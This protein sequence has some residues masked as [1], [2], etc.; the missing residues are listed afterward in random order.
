MWDE[1][2]LHV[3]HQGT[4]CDN[5]LR[6]TALLSGNTLGLANPERPLLTQKTCHIP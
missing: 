3:T 6:V 5:I 4:A 1:M 2:H